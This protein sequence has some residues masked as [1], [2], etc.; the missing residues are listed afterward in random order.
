MN[1]VWK[2]KGVLQSDGW[3]EDCFVSTDSKGVIT[4]ISTETLA[5]QSEIETVN[6]WALP[7]FQNAH[8]HSFQYAMSG[9]AEIHPDPTSTDDF[10]SWRETMYNLALS[11]DPDDF[12]HIAAMLYSEMLSHGYT[13]V[14]E[15]HYVHHDKKGNHYDNKSEMGERL[16]AAAQQV[17]IGITLIPIFY[18]KGGFGLAAGVKQRR[19]I[20]RNSNDYL[21]L[22]DASKESIQSYNKANLGIGIH[23]L[24]AVDAS[25]ITEALAD[26]RDMPIHLHISEQ[27]KE[28]EDC[29]AFNKQRPVEW[30]H[31]NL[32]VSDQFHLVHAT[33]LDENEVSQIC[34]SGAH[35]VLCPSTEGNLGD[36]IFPLKS[37]QEQGGKWSIGTDSHI[38]INPLEEL[39]IL[40]Y[41]QRLTT[42]QRNQFIHSKNGDCGRFSIDMALTSGRKA[43]G[44]NAQEFFQVGDSLDTVILDCNS[45]L[46]AASQSEN[47]LATTVYAGDRSTFKGTITNGKW[48]IKNGMHH[49]QEEIIQPFIRTMNKLQIR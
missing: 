27:L 48:R 9:L 41:G 31:N 16:V 28:I 33:H 7:G 36:G 43:M 29:L 49:S 19:F 44:N 15:F 26:A 30:I 35:V 3:I 11:M 24:R 42:H 1:K 6:G 2:F 23:S 13:H 17:G 14:A 32:E 12:Q 10:W 45:P 38:G 25:S 22:L 8:S 34:N 37:F 46:L 21:T 5:Q 20:S 18:Q 47:I 4:E 39:R 40:D